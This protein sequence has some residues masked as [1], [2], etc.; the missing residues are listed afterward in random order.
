VT[1]PV[2]DLRSESSFIP[3][4]Q[5]VGRHRYELTTPALVLD[6]SILRRNIATMAEWTR[7]HAKIRPHA[8][9]HKCA[10]IARLQVAAGAAGI[11]VATVWEAVAMADAGLD[12]ILIANEVVGK[13]KLTRLAQAARETNFL[14]AVDSVA[15][16]DALSHAALSAGTRIGVLIEIDVGMRR[17]G[18]RTPTEA[19]SLAAALSRLAGIVL[20]GVMGFEGHVVTEPNRALRATMAAEAM[21]RLIACVEILERAGFEIEIVSAGGTNTY[22]MTGANPRVTELQAGTY[23][24][25][26]TAY[27]PLVPAFKPALTILGTVMSRNERTAVLDFGTKVMAMDLGRPA[28]VEPCA[29]VR[30]VHEEHTLL[31]VQD[32][33]RLRVGEAVEIVV[34]Y[35]GGTV[36]L[37]DVY[38]VV[39]NDQVVDVWPILARGPGRSLVA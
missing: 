6:A 7:T 18:V 8:K 2:G 9:T 32:D 29:T 36:N 37:N 20:R 26:D 22:D 24:L 27:G 13:E 3:Y 30:A 38:H 23:V 10:E 28:L 31:D 14:V 4:R 15:G 1:T 21:E 11:T 17:G 16:A 34:G 19:C 12:N 5:S 35:C 33:A 25:M 39:E